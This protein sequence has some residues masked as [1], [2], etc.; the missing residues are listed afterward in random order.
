[1]REKATA[2]LKRQ[3]YMYH[4]IFQKKTRYQ[5]SLPYASA[6]EVFLAFMETITAGLSNTG[7][8][9]DIDPHFQKD[10]DCWF[11]K[12]LANEVFAIT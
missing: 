8:P 7:V 10:A 12:H 3:K 6:R 11:S 5:Q 4:N 1:M 9:I 2:M